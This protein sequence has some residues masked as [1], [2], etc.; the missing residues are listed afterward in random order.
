MTSINKTKTKTEI[1]SRR[2]RRNLRR[3]KRSGV[4]REAGKSSKNVAEKLEAL[5]NL[6]PSSINNANGV[7]K[8]DQIF[9]E[10][11]DYI[12]FLR[13]QVAIL[14]K[15]IHFYDSHN[16]NLVFIY[17]CNMAS[18]KAFKIFI[19]LPPSL[20]F[21]LAIFLSLNALSRVLICEQF[22]NLV[23]DLLFR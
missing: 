13:T 2:N 4:C 8:A 11:A 3:A 1:T 5:K 15:L 19:E 16:K 21:S 18:M 20:A 14:Q 9:E 6:I 23:F 12:V 22:L 10:T 17:V 7:M